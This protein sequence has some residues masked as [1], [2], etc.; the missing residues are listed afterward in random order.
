M[1]ARATKLSMI[2]ENNI[3]F[4]I[5]IYQRT[6]DWNHDH[7]D[8]LYDDIEKTGQDK[9][10]QSH[11]LGAITYLTEYPMADEDISYYQ[12]ID[13]QQRLTTLMLLLRALKDRLGNGT[14]ILTEGKIN[15]LLFNINEK[16]ERY[17]KL[18]LTEN[19]NQ[20]FRDILKNGKTD[21]SNNIVANFKRFE[22]LLSKDKTNLDVIWRGIQKLTL[23]HI[24]IDA[25]D[26][27][28]EIFESMN[29]TG[30]DL[31]DT[32]MIKNYMLMSKDSRWQERIYK[33]YWDPMEQR[34]GEVR[35]ED[36][37]EFIRNYLMMRRGKIV[38][39][40]EMYKYFK[41]YM[42]GL[43]KEDEIK[44]ISKY[45]KYYANLIGI[46]PH[47]SEDLKEV[48]GYVY[49]Q[50]TN[51]AY[52]L[53]LKIL[54]DYDEGIIDLKQACS[55][56]LLVDSYLLRCHVC[57]MTKAGNKIFPE[58]IPK[59]DKIDYVKSIE[60]ILMLKTGNRRFPRDVT[61]REKLKQ[62]PLYMNR[63]MCK[64][65][66]VRLENKDKEKIETN[67]IQIEHIMPQTLN[68]EWKKILGENWNEIHEK[69]V[70]SIGNLT[71]TGYNPDLGNKLFSIKQ[72][73]YRK[74]SVGLTRELGTYLDWNEDTIKKR[75]ELLTEETIKLWK[76]PQEYELYNN[77]GIS[78]DEYLDGKE[79]IDLWNKL[80]EKI[81]SICKEVT[82]D[83]TQRYGVFRLPFQNNDKNVVICSIA[84]RKSKILLFYNI[85]IHDNI[86][87]S[88]K[89]VRD[90]S[91]IG[92]HAT[93]ELCST[94]YTQED[95]DK[96]IDL[97][98]I[99]Y[100][101]RSKDTS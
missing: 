47:H 12:V 7:C 9:T 94:I 67:D 80:K 11:F 99:I 62:L 70:H 25:N 92:H 72:E 75:M 32:D 27:P 37:D 50:D 73:T 30:L 89:F 86:I 4:K 38:P 93:G 41:N 55:I 60:K 1:E 58:I 45:C 5:P 78:E 43:D 3:Q 79:I 61:F 46:S 56:F 96:A 100:N 24:R 21:E 29:S 59:I 26:N 63:T 17:H 22:S 39:K 48:I 42:S 23:V 33:D 8:Q 98:R 76:C 14:E 15:Q 28:Q 40:K 19:D 91:N 83:I 6:Y 34:F 81:S 64:Y 101:K 18:V 71:L 44:N 57:G 52:S 85:K 54:A 95:I 51:V 84:A 66:L 88:S 10:K 53:L 16:E 31:S 13:G 35:S 69:Y 90:I 49:E 65:M 82:F 20:S 2:L 97:V 74:S 77:E 87:P 68:S 36:F